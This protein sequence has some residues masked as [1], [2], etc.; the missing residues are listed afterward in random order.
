LEVD[1]LT[2]GNLE[3][4]IL[5]ARNLEVDILT[6]CNLKMDSLTVCHL[7]I[8]FLTVCNLKVGISTRHRQSSAGGAFRLEGLER[9]SLRRNAVASFPTLTVEVRK[10]RAKTARLDS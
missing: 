1:G 4:D 2:V 6:I 8:D 9:L 3:V 7:K 10:K 5:N